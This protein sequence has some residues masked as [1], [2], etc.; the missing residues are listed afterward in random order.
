MYDDDRLDSIYDKTQGKCHICGKKLARKNYGRTDERGA[1]E[2][3]HS[4]PR[5]SGGTDRLNNL[6]VA[7][8]AGHRAKQDGSTRTA[9]AQHGRTRAPLSASTERRA[10]WGSAIGWGLVARLVGGAVLGPAG[11]WFVALLAGAVAFEHDPD[12]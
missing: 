1:W 12:K 11:G 9:R 4:N 7:C 8:V 6:Y 10:R 2:V 5:A 3:E